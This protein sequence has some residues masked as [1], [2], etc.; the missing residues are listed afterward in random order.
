MSLDSAIGIGFPPIARHPATQGGALN[1]FRKGT[2][3]SAP[4][5]GPNGGL[6]NLKEYEV[7]PPFAIH[8]KRQV[9]GLL[10]DLRE[11]RIAAGVD[12]RQE[13]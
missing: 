4:L 9:I 8:G 2:S 11:S 7:V 12:L 1:A 3:R 5:A 10:Y 13:I 6:A